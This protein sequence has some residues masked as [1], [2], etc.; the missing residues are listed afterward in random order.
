MSAWRF[1]DA[2][3]TI[4]RSGDVVGTGGLPRM[5]TVL[6]VASGFGVLS[7]AIAFMLSVYPLISQL[8]S[9]GLQLADLGALDSKERHE[10]CGK[11]RTELGATVRN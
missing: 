9:T 3:I 1:S 6:E 4:A 5:V 7:A 8:G 2:A 11:W 10:S